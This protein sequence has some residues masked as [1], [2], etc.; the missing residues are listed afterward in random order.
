MYFHG[1][2]LRRLMKKNVWNEMVYL[3]FVFFF[4]S[5]RGFGSCFRF[6]HLAVRYF[7][8][9]PMLLR[10]FGKMIFLSYIDFLRLNQIILAYEIYH[11]NCMK[12]NS[13]TQQSFLVKLDKICEQLS[14]DR[15][16]K[17]NKLRKKRKFQENL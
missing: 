2:L 5:S 14:S 15:E 6:L 11:R 8:G 3:N 1:V 9:R 10:L 16:G 17:T 12:P 13:L 4:C 7:P